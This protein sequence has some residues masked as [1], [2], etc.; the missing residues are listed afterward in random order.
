MA[1]TWYYAKKL[2][3]DDVPTNRQ[4]KCNKM[5]IK[6]LCHRLIGMYLEY[7]Y[8]MLAYQFM[9]NTQG[10]ILLEG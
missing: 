10:S 1:A 2:K 7:V 6:N 9:K 5:R 4:Q 3:I 8:R